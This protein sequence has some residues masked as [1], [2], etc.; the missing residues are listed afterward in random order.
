MTAKITIT[1]CELRDLVSP[2]LPLASKDSMLPILNAV[3]IET[4]GKWLS[5]SAT[6]RF[7]LGIKRIEKRP[8]EDDPTTE[9]APFRAV[10]PLPALRSLL[11]VFKPSRHLDPE[12]TLR[13]RR[14]SGRRERRRLRP[15]RLL[16]PVL[17]AGGRAVPGSPQAR[18]RRPGAR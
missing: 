4:D 6:D 10:V 8:T 13:R 7:R 14:R 9:W 5:A 2:V 1:A 17:L 18:A 16:A 11:S 12:L 15:V 3:L